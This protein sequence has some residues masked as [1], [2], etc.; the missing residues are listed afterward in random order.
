MQAIKDALEKYYVDQVNAAPVADY[1]D[2]EKDD[3]VTFF[4]RIPESEK[5]EKE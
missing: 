1:L 2:V 4:E 5:E 3:D